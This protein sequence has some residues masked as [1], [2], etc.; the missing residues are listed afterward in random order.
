M[1]D[2][3]GQVVIQSQAYDLAAPVNAAVVEVAHRIERGHLEPGPSNLALLRDL[4]GA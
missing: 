3:N 2:I 4:A 1:D